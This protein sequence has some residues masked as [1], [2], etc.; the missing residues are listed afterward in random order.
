M[1]QQHPDTAA[2]EKLKD[3]GLT[4]ADSSQEI[5]GRKVVDP[6]GAEIGQ[7]SGLFIDLDERKVRM[8]EIRVGG[9][10]GLGDQHF[11]LPVDA[12]T[13]LDE[14]HVYV[15][16]TQER[17]VRSPAYD[18]TLIVAPTHKYLDPYYAYY[19]IAPFGQAGYGMSD[20]MSIR[21]R[22]IGR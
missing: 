7:V 13:R 17:V 19:G 1:S 18:P 12:I 3:T 14:D 10:L 6:S 22:P 21:S 4:L 9:F 20:D 5:R 8:I 16:E 15:N 11:L 2:L